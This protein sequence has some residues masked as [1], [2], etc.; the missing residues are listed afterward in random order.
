M[1]ILIANQGY[2]FA[3]DAQTFTIR[4]NL[5]E[6][7][8]G[9]VMHWALVAG[10][11]ELEKASL[12]LEGAGER[13]V[14]V[15]VPEV[16]VITEMRLRVRLAD[17]EGKV[18]EQADVPVYVFPQEL[19][20][21]RAPRLWKDKQTLLVGET[22]L[23]EHLGAVTPKPQVLSDVQ[24]LQTHPGD[25][26]IIGEDVLTETDGH[27][28]IVRAIADGGA[29]VLI[30]KQTA[31][32]VAGLA[33]AVGR[34]NQPAYMNMRHPILAGLKREMLQSMASGVSVLQLGVDDD[35][36]EV[37]WFESVTAGREPAPLDALIT[38][39][40]VGAGRV[41]WCQ[42]PVGEVARD[43]R[44]KVLLDNLLAYAA[45]RP[46][47]TPRRSDRGGTLILIPAE[48]REIAV[49]GGVGK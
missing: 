15:K 32:T 25:L 10:G 8:D 35:V 49:P 38:V 9:A 22:G 27:E 18:L 44:S 43:P 39:Q 31:T 47:P 21:S 4:P 36:M 20:A 33:S 14:K 11:I 46:E 30:L 41:I 2:W 1:L 40:R 23:Q 34:E 19:R 48:E 3:G 26:V 45:V 6:W 5:R 16:R 24:R 7:P 37:M 28:A 42:L 29:T 12:Q 13:E 17:A